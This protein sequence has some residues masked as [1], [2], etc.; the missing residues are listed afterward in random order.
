MVHAMIWEVHPDGPRWS[1]R[2]TTAG[3]VLEA[4]RWA[5]FGA[6]GSALFAVVFFGVDWVARAAA[7]VAV[8][9]T[10]A[11]TVAIFTGFGAFFAF[12]VRMLRY[13]HWVIDREARTLAHSVRRVFADAQVAEVPFD[14][15]DRIEVS[16]N[17]VT[18]LFA[19]GVREVLAS[20]PVARLGFE[21]VLLGLQRAFDETGLQVVVVE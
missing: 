2:R 3:R 16:P 18:V 14:A 8:P 9:P 19:D 11:L 4:V 21:D 10:F 6:A 20:T 17:V 5:A 15:I 7:E 1:L 12:V 13:R